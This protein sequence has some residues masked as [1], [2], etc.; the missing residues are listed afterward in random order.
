MDSVVAMVFVPV[1]VKPASQ[2]MVVK[3][4]IGAS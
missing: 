1:A 3:H 4:S 2:A